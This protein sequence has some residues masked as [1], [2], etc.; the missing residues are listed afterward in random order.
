MIPR[1]R[2]IYNACVPS[3]CVAFSLAV[4][5]LSFPHSGRAAHVEVFYAPE[6]LPIERVVTL[7]GH[8]KRYIY[9]AVYGMTS[10][11][12]V[13]A[14]VEAKHRGVDVRVITD[15]ERMT[16]PKQRTAAKALHTA[17][18]PIRVNQHD[19]LMHLKQVVIDDEVNTSGSAN[20]TTSGN[21][22]NDERLDVI[23]DRVV[24]AKAREK[25]L[26]LWNDR[27]RFVAWTGE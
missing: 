11:A 12:V 25:F 20:Q 8:A 14:L 16:D 7:Y 4:A 19:G 23:T 27:D 26:A 2:S 3:V 13:K 6:D 21:R 5:S 9:V 10:P 1:S 17:G 22:Y 18:V 24:T 15:R